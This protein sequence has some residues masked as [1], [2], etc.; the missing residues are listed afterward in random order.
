MPIKVS[1]K[2]VKKGSESREI[3]FSTNHQTKIVEMWIKTRNWDFDN[4]EGSWEIKDVSFNDEGKKEN[5]VWDG[6]IN[7]WMLERNT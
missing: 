5:C 3:S 2:F 7:K 6:I 4:S 1:I